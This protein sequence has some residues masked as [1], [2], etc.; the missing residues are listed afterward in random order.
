MENRA[1]ESVVLAAA[2]A[3]VRRVLDGSRAYRLLYL[4]VLEHCREELPE[5]EAREFVER[6]KSS[7]CQIRDAGSLLETL[8]GSKGLARRIVVDGKDYE[9]TLSD[10]QGDE[11]IPPEASVDTFVVTTEAGWVALGQER[12]LLSVRT[13]LSEKPE[14]KEAFAR[15]LEACS[16]GEGASTNELFDV[17]DAEGFLERDPSNGLPRV[18]PSYFTSEL[19]RV[20][21]LDWNGKKWAVSERGRVALAELGPVATA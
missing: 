5:W 2:V 13:L 12:E 7:S 4:D 16:S 3:N 10:L 18:Y 1:D 19:E 11:T 20:G 21:A 17:L 14:R 6:S 9:G 8:V 15:T